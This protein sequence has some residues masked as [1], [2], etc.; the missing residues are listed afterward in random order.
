MPPQEIIVIHGALGSASQMIPIAETLGAIAPVRLIELPGHGNTPLGE[1]DFSIA[2]FVR[3]LGTDVGS[4]RPIAF[5]YSLGGYVALALEA[6]APGTF[7]GIVTYGTKFAWNP[8]ESAREVKLLDASTIATKVPAFAA[9]LQA[10]HEG[11]GGWELVLQRTAT[12]ITAAGEDSLLTPSVLSRIRPP[13][14]VS[15]GTVDATVSVQETAAAALLVE[16][17]QHVFLEGLP[18]AI[19]KV[20]MAD[21]AALV[22]GIAQRAEAAGGQF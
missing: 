1:R 21:I 10:R 15:V 4:G 6:T 5:G 22:R 18:H 13:V 17:G 3:S 2:G 11:A 16:N 12:L 8:E 14:T 9:A 19:E 20:P 7:A